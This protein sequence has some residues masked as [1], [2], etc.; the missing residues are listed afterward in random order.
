MNPFGVMRNG[1]PIEDHVISKKV[2]ANIT[3]NQS[4]AEWEACIAAN[5]D[6]ERWELGTY[7]GWLKERA[8]AWHHLHNLVENNVQDAM[9]KAIERER[10]RA[11]K[12]KR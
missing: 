8:V 2:N 11:A 12:R 7:P 4:Y 5:L 1:E 10:K 6:I 9:N 3:Y